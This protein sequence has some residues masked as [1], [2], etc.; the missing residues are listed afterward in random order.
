MFSKIKNVMMKPRTRSRLFL[1]LVLLEPQL[2]LVFVLVIWKLFTKASTKQL[3]LT[4]PLKRKLLLFLLAKSQ[5]DTTKEEFLMLNARTKSD[6][7][8]LLLPR[9]TLNKL[10][11]LFARNKQKK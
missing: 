2:V 3:R 10:S 5:R 6:K 9:E 11:I 4:L 1:M 7:N 8:L